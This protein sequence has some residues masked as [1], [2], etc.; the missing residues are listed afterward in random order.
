MFPKWKYHK[1]K[2]PFLIHNEAEEAALGDAWAE[3]PFSKE[4]SAPEVPVKTREQ[5]LAEMADSAP[6]EQSVDSK[7]KK[8]A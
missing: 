4:E 7:S 5:I 8:K 2:E 1:T 3:A 6:V